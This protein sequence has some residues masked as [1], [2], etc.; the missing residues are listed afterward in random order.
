MRLWI[1]RLRRTGTRRT[2]ATATLLANTRPNTHAHKPQ[3]TQWWTLSTSML[4][5]CIIRIMQMKCWSYF[6]HPPRHFYYDFNSVHALYKFGNSDYRH[7]SQLCI[8]KVVF[9]SFHNSWGECKS[10]VQEYCSSL[11]AFSHF[12][13]KTKWGSTLEFFCPQ[14]C[15]NLNKCVVWH[16][17]S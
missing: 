14:V 7:K 12:G 8:L 16:C 11:F 13:N 9:K 2:L 3:K 5:N 4:L 15:N 1:L 10:C 6:G 17:V